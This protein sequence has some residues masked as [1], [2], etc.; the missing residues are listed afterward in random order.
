M[1]G[2]ARRAR[3]R[4]RAH[5]EQDSKGHVPPPTAQG[6]P[7]GRPPPSK[8]A[9]RAGRSDCNFPARGRPWGAAC[10]GPHP[11]TKVGCRQPSPLASP[12]GEHW[13]TARLWNVGH[14]SPQGR[15]PCHP[16]TSHPRCRPT[17]GS[18]RLLALNRPPAAAPRPPAPTLLGT[19]S[20]V[21]AARTPR[22]L[23]LLGS[24]ARTQRGS[25]AEGRSGR[26]SVR[27]TTVGMGQPVRPTRPA[28]QGDL[29]SR[30]RLPPALG[31]PPA[32]APWG[33]WCGGP[34]PQGGGV[35]DLLGLRWL[36]EE[37]AGPA[38]PR[39]PSQTAPPAQ[40]HGTQA[41]P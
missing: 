23:C 27:A 26:P 28:S 36:L 38:Q 19:A 35:A 20:C 7:A 1:A 37:R 32:L 12:C 30:P 24:D 33:P 18:A 6:R 22:R 2:A 11:G 3:A 4:V 10:P 40:P 8:T 31:V 39:T 17:K 41:A 16:P 34:G 25:P 21:P 5:P 15:E 29:A 13:L 14:P 9:G